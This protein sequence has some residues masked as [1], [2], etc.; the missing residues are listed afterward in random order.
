MLGY[1]I[2]IQGKNMEIKI[3][4]WALQS[5]L[6]LNDIFSE[7]EYREIIRPDTELL[8]EYL[9]HP[10]F[11]NDKF[12]GPC[13]DKSGK[14]IH[15]GYKMKWHNIGSGKVQLRLLIVIADKTAYIC[16]AYVKDNES[17]DFRKMS[18]LKIK[19]Q[20]INEGNLPLQ[21]GG[22]ELCAQT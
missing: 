1:I 7:K 10:K 16:N 21:K 5:Y 19:I 15:Q 18:K 8:Y 14:I 22:Y 3:T 20:Q 12:W 6:E 2:I 9:R 17:T 11:G 4:D 13:K